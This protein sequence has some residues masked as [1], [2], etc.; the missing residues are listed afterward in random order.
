MFQ[1]VLYEKRDAI[2]VV[3][4]NRPRQLNAFNIQ[5]RDD[6]WEVLSA[7]RQDD[8]VRAVVLR[9]EGERGFCSGADLTE[10]GT[11]PSRVVAREARYA[12]DVWTSLRALSVPVVAAL[13]GYVIGSGI[14]LAMH[15]DLRIASEDA[16]FS[17]PE[18]ALGM[19]PFAGGTQTVARATGRARVLDLL[20]TGRRIDA[21]EA[22]SIGLVHRVVGR[23]RLGDE[24]MALARQLAEQPRSAIGAAKRA[25]A[26]GADLPLHNGLRLE[27]ILVSSLITTIYSS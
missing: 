1:T 11:T 19:L 3:S 20:L 27:G 24:A 9:G 18:V 12:R 21:A 14:E 26:E 23:D 7:I 13:H 2:G 22:L 6:L 25:V 5:M 15:C 10:F 8:E 17:L 4:L 16:V